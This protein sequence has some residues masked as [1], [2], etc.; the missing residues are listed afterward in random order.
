[1]D[2]QLRRE[3]YAFATS[4]LPGESKE[5][6]FMVPPSWTHVVEAA[7]GRILVA[8]LVISE[9]ITLAGLVV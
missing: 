7:P 3:T 5:V 8:R 9:R 4:L 6:G 2:T 1:M